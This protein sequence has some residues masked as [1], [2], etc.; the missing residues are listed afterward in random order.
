MN[1]VE[2]QTEAPAYDINEIKDAFLKYY[3]LLFGCKKQSISSKTVL[4]WLERLRVE[5][6][7]PDSIHAAYEHV[8]EKK[9]DASRYISESD[10][11]MVCI[12]IERNKSKSSIGD[13]NDFFKNEFSKFSQKM[14]FKYRS[15]WISQ[16]KLDSTESDFWVNELVTAKVSPHSFDKIF[17]HI[18]AD[19]EF[20]RYPP[21]IDQVI[22]IYNIISLNEPI[23]SASQA[24]KDALSSIHNC[25]KLVKY[26]R[27]NYGNHELRTQSSSVSKPAFEKMYR[28]IVRRY[29]AGEIQIPEINDEFSGFPTV[30]STTILSTLDEMIAK[31]S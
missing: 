16:D 7:S 15:L 22:Y 3:K 1:L 17:E 26:C 10:F 20:I 9:T 12:R 31:Y 28:E 6:V 8:M 23:P 30:P 24:Y 25:H 4:E 5:N 13:G 29:A 27:K 18:R 11:L 19:D 14:M 2:S 21:N